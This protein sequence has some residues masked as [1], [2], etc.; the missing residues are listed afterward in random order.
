MIVAF[1][2]RTRLLDSI[3]FKSGVIGG[4]YRNVKWRLS[5][6]TVSD[7]SDGIYTYKYW[8]NFNMIVGNKVQNQW[9]GRYSIEED[10]A[11]VARYLIDQIIDG[12]HV[13]QIKTGQEM[14]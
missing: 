9:R 13:L 1:I 8:F 7:I 4:T 14:N 10:T 5:Q 3:T 2:N 12:Y 11:S 6:R